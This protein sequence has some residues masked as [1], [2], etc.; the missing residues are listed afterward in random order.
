LNEHN[1]SKDGF[2]LVKNIISEVNDY[3]DGYIIANYTL[4]E[5]LKDK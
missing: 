5:F 2:E 3:V 4:L 1:Y